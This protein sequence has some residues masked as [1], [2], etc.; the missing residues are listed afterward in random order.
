M[1]GDAVAAPLAG[2]SSAGSGDIER[3][4]TASLRAYRAGPRGTACTA[5]RRPVPSVFGDGHL[6]V[7]VTPKV[8]AT[9]C[10]EDAELAVQPAWKMECT[11]SVGLGSVPAH[12]Q[13]MPTN[14]PCG[15]VRLA[16]GPCGTVF[17]G[18]RRRRAAME[19]ARRRCNVVAPRHRCEP[20]LLERLLPREERHGHLGLAQPGLPVLAVAERAEHKSTGGCA[21]APGAAAAQQPPD[22]LLLGTA[23]RLP[24]RRAAGEARRASAHGGPAFAAPSWLPGL[25]SRADTADRQ[26][27]SGC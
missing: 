10:S 2:S 4:S 6:E 20:P 1:L 15:Q 13:R 21:G 25:P 8:S 3:P 7:S 17:A 14:S 11:P 23:A 9:R 12:S 16:H 5:C 26:T 22:P 27:D 18:P 19:G 24:V